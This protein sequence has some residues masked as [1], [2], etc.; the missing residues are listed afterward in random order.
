MKV[1]LFKQKPF[2]NKDADRNYIFCRNKFPFFLTVFFNFTRE[3][4]WNTELWERRIE[5]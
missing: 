2:I 3:E 5:R 4:T 1:Q